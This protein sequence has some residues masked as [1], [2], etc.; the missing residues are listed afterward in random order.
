[1][2]WST[3]H[4]L[5][6][7]LFHHD[8][9]EDPVLGYVQASEALFIGMLLVVIALARHA[10][11]A[12]L[13]RTAV[14]AGLSAALGLLVGKIITEFWDRPRP[15]VAHPGQVHLFIPHVAD[16]SFPSD[17]ATAAAAIAVA[18]LLRRRV[19]WGV[20]TLVFTLILMYGRVALGFHYPTD[21]LGG[22]ALGSAA[23]IL[24][25][26]APVRQR[27]DMLSDRAGGLWD[28]TLDGGLALAGVGQ[29]GRRATD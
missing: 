10:R 12:G 2:D 15:F 20:V 5:N 1:M 25:F 28:R 16:A 27:V 14:A 19:W 18:I 8:A 17:H 9:I 29:S 24:L 7:F 4:A 26:A 21:V 3:A 23:A 6:L 11:W 13:R 22:A